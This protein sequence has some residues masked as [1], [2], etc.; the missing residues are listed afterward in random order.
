M[1]QLQRHACRKKCQTAAR[2]SHLPRSGAKESGVPRTSGENPRTLGPPLGAAGISQEL[3]EKSVICPRNNPLPVPCFR[4][5]QCA[6]VAHAFPAVTSLPEFP[7]DWLR[8]LSGVERLSSRFLLLPYRRPP[9][10]PPFSWR[11]SI[12]GCPAVHLFPSV[13]AA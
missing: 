6:S 1:R 8:A 11:A 2:T 7:F 12:S 5:F 13:S 9:A 10:C 3:D 4:V